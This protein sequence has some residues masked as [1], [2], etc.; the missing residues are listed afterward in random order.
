MHGDRV[1]QPGGDA[2]AGRILG[3][4]AGFSLLDSANL[5]VLLFVGVLNTVLSLFYYLRVVKVMVMSPE[6][7]YRNARRIPLFSMAG[8]YCAMLTLPVVL[9]FFL[10][11]GLLRWAHTAASALFR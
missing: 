11:N 5:K 10:P 1:V 4:V 3:Q 8:S 7:L 2:P 6:P 9:W